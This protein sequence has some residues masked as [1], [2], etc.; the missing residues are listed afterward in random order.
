M[1]DRPHVLLWG[2]AQAAADELVNIPAT[3][4]DLRLALVNALKRIERLEARAGQ[5]EIGF[6]K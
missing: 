4:E 2:S 5:T 6:F 3:P 1:T